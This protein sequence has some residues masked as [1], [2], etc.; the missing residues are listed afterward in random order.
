MMVIIQFT[1]YLRQILQS[2]AVSVNCSLSKYWYLE[3][4]FNLILIHSHFT[5]K[6]SRFR[7]KKTQIKAAVTPTQSLSDPNHGH[8]IAMSLEV[9]KNEAE[10]LTFFFVGSVPSWRLLKAGSSKIYVWKY[11][12]AEYFFPS[13]PP[14]KPTFSSQNSQKF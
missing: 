6:I 13:F 14:K 4:V 7:D 5:L 8:L 11:Y 3:C 1:T 9:L 2:N 10:K 12:S